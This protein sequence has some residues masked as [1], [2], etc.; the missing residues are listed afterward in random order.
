M[1]Q[2]K[3]QT[4]MTKTKQYMIESLNKKRSGDATEEYFGIFILLIIGLGTVAVING[5]ASTASVSAFA[6]SNV[7]AAT[8]YSLIPLF[9]ALFFVIIIA[10]ASIAVYRRKGGKR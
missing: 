9:I 5:F 2:S 4:Y 6:Q 1:A 8:L 3:S 7:N 10:A